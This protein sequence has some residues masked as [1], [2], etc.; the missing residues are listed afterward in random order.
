MTWNERVRRAHRWL[1]I[2]FTVT[3]VVTVV[4]LALKGPVWVSYVPLAPL[5]LLLLSGLGIF[6]SWYAATRRSRAASIPQ[7][8]AARAAAPRVRRLHRG[9]GI[10][11]VATVLATFVALAQEQP[12]I[13][14]SYLPLL[15]LALL[16]F[17]GLYMLVEPF[18]VRRRGARRAA[19]PG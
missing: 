3:I 9:S 17:S 4:V 19:Q 15:P 12:V 14:V 18:S 2:V 8:G 5:A 13:W 16:L 1:A 10:V 7:A 11:F 6:V